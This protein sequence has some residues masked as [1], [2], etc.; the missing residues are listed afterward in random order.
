MSVQ[1]AGRMKYLLLV[2]GIPILLM[3]LL[4]QLAIAS[5][6]PLTALLSNI[7]IYTPISIMAV[8]GY[9]L[10]F[11]KN[12]CIDV[13]DNTVI[14]TDWRGQNRRVIKTSQIWAYRRNILG[15]IILLDKLG[16][17]LLCVE[18]N[19]TNF[20]AFQKWLERHDILMIRRNRNGKSYI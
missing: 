16:N 3:Y 20:D 9:F 1:K 17:R 11:K 8:L 10:I 4:Q 6:L 2:M 13:K 12:H 15:E 19:M 14:E 18:S 5:I 7:Y